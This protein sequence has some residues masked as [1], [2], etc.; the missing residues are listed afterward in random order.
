VGVQV[1]TTDASIGNA[2]TANAIMELPFYGRNVV[3][4]LSFQPDVTTD[5]N[6]N[7]GKS[8]EGNVT[9]DGVDV[10][11]Q[12]TRAAFS[13][14]LRVTLDSVQEFRTTT[15]NANAAAAPWAGRSRRT[16]SSLS[17]T[18]KAGA[19]PALPWELS[20]T[21]QKASGTPV[22]VGNCRCWPTNWN[23]APN[24]EATGPV[25]TEPTK[26]APSVAG[27]GGAN[28]FPDP[29]VALKSYTNPLPGQAGHRSV[30]RR[31]GPFVI[32]TL[33]AKTFNLFTLH[34][35]PHLLQ[36]RWEAFNLTNTTRFTTLSLDLGNSG[37]FGKY[38]AAS[39]PRQMQFALRY[40]F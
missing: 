25:T 8:D 31:Q 7:G 36:F 2:I 6:V 17:A 9:L 34:D 32:N 15:T 5:G 28:L 20:P 4:L 18:M 14:V 13:S 24:A 30:L 16:R 39:D 33:G 40:M 1:N 3:D 21:F 11:N 38:S 23:L 27:T 10:N 29:N 35:N 19:M 26:N 22:S 12:N 37:T